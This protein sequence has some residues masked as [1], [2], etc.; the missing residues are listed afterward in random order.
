[1]YLKGYRL[2][3]SRGRDRVDWNSEFLFCRKFQH[4][5]FL[6]LFQIGMKIWKF[7]NS[8]EI[9]FHKHFVLEI[10]KWPYWNETFHYYLADKNLS[11]NSFLRLIKSMFFKWKMSENFRPA[12]SR[13]SS[14]VLW[15]KHLIWHCPLNWCNCNCKYILLKPETAFSSKMLHIV[16]TSNTEIC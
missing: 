5:E 12:L 4:F 10:L 6:F 1:M 13:G 9:K 7:K 2:E 15:V 8:C 16:Y 3:R 14:R 11:V